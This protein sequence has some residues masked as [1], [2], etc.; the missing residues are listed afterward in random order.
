M[1]PPASTQG[2]SCPRWYSGSCRH[3][4][5]QSSGVPP[6]R[7]FTALRSAFPRSTVPMQSRGSPPSD[8]PPASPHPR[9][10]LA[11]TYYRG[12]WHVVSW[13]RYRHFPLSL[14]AP[15]Q[16]SIVQIDFSFPNPPPFRPA[17]RRCFSS[18]PTFPSI[19]YGFRRMGISSHF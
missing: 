10:T 3:L 9:I 5:V 7:T 18:N 13:F 15:H 17:T 2:F 19:R 1:V 8:L 11:P 12:R 6:Y 16:V 14:A 4:T